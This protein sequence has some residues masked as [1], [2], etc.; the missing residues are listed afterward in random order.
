MKVSYPLSL[1][2]SLWLML[3]LLLLAALGIGFF[4]VRGGLGWGA[5]IAGRPGDRAQALFNGIAG[6]ASAAASDMRS[7]V[8]HRFGETYGA[9]FGIFG[10][11]ESQVA[12]APMAL[13]PE[14]RE[15]MEFRG[16]GW[17]FFGG[18]RGGGP[19]ARRGPEGEFE[20]KRKRE[21]GD[22]P[23]PEP[24]EKG[25]FGPEGPRRGGEGGPAPGFGGPPPPDRITGRFV[26][27]GGTPAGYWVGMRVPFVQP[28][29]GSRPMPAKLVARVGSLWGL[30]N[31]LGLQSLLLGAGGVLALSVL[32][33][34]PLVRS[35]TH[36][37][38]QLTA[39]TEKIAE[40]RFDTRV[41]AHRRDEIGQLGE[42]VNRMAAQLDAHMNGQK[43]FLGDVA[44]ELC[45]PLARLQMATGILAEQAPKN[46]S[47]TVADVRDE[48]QQMSTLV[49]E[50]LAFTKSGLQA[51]EVTLAPTLLESLAR[52]A[53]HREGGDG[54]ITLDVPADL[55]AHA[56][57]DMLGRAVGNLV[58]NALR[59]AGAAGPIAVRAARDGDRISLA[60]EDSGP[61]VPAADLGRLGEPFFRPELARTREGGG[62]G[63]GLAIVRNSVAACGGEVRFSNREPQGFRA[64][65]RLR[66]A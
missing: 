62:V 29:R 6:E 2:V 49:N 64:E 22:G 20:P 55:A 41:A 37:L 59:Y 46:L 54:K 23:P 43:R 35:I 10:L 50:L 53:I 48:V 61:G 27:R 57:G 17:A 8:L 42:S 30:L 1:K 9:E 7:A 25:R 18:P 52:A 36:S 14:V 65:I 58:R 45:S 11:D 19:G 3:N 15:R 28:E 47:D 44:H 4:V 21:P 56:D 34:L 5:L 66:A 63:L 26:V 33:W 32:F 12:G 38:G 40:G 51:R 13:P 16:A 39:A 24:P 31:L 60:V